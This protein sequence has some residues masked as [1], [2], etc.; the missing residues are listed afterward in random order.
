MVMKKPNTR[1][2]AL[3]N[4]TAIART[5]GHVLG[6]GIVAYSQTAVFKRNGG[7]FVQMLTETRLTDR[8]WMMAAEGPAHWY[9]VYTR[10]RFEK[11]V[12]VALQAKAIETYLPLLRKVHSWKDH[13]KLLEIPVF[14]GYFF[15]R[16]PDCGE[17]RLSILTSAGVIRILGHGEQLNPV[18]EVEI[19]SIRRLLSSAFPCFSNPFLKEGEWVRV[20]RGRIE[21]IKG[22]LLRLKNHTCLVVS[23]TLLYQSVAAEIEIRDVEVVRSCGGAHWA[24]MVVENSDYG[25]IREVA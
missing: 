21:G 16:L 17:T 20:K 7:A 4:K 6:R 13:K 22:S 15:A 8:M 24:S 25:K 2:S 19:Q 5:T 18:S 9:A 1:R 23:V 14:P 12:A 10:S 11:K 3:S